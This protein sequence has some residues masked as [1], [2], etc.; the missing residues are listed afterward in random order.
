MTTFPIHCKVEKSDNDRASSQR[1]P[2][3]GTRAACDQRT[4]FAQP[5][6]TLC[7]LDISQNHKCS[8]LAAQ[9]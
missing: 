6:N 3:I 1:G 7:L 4:V 8:A 5:A 9:H 2:N